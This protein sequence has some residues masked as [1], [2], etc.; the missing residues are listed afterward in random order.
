[1]NARAKAGMGLER[2]VIAQAI[3]DMTMGQVGG[4]VMRG[5]QSPSF[6]GVR[7]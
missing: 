6:A 7:Y 5:I 1:M 4:P 3:A 2:K